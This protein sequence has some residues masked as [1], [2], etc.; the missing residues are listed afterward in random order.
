M[1][2]II[3]EENRWYPR[4]ETDIRDGPVERLTRKEIVEAMQK[5]KSEKAAGLSG[6]TVGTIM[7]SGEIGTKVMKD[8]CL[9]VLDVEECLMSGKLEKL[10][11]YLTERVR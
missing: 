1:E 8:R 11:L 9:H 7:A 10:C 6:I 3:N 5:I 2:K 4:V